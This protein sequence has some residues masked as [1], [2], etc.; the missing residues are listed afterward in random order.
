MVSTQKHIIH[1][2]TVDVETKNERAAFQLKDTIDVF[3]KEDIFP[4]IEA[5]FSSLEEKFQEQTI[6]ISELNIDVN[7]SGNNDFREL[8]EEIK[9]QAFKEFEKIIKSPK[10]ENDK[11]AFLNANQSEER[12]LLYFLEKG[13]P[14]WWNGSN[15]SGF[16]QEK[17]LIEISHS[18]SFLTL[19]RERIQKKNIQNRLVNQFLDKEIQI[20]LKNVFKKE[21][22]KIAILKDK[23][24]EK[25]NELK[26]NIRASI[27]KMYID[28]FLH[29][30]ETIFSEKL[31]A[32]V[33]A[34]GVGNSQGKSNKKLIEIAQFICKELDEKTPKNKLFNAFSFT[35]N[36]QQIYRENTAL[37]EVQNKEELQ[38]ESDMYFGQ[39][40]EQKKEKN[41]TKKNIENNQKT[42]SKKEINPENLI[43]VELRK[44][45]NENK[46]IDS[47]NT[48][49]RVDLTDGFSDFN[50]GSQSRNQEFHNDVSID[51]SMSLEEV[52]QNKIGYSEQEP[53][54][55]NKIKNDVKIISDKEQ[56]EVIK[57]NKN[58]SSE[59]TVFS[60]ETGEY[61]MQNVGLILLHPYLNNFFS[62]CN[63]LTSKKQIS[64]PELAVHLVHYLATKKEQQFECNM[65]FEKF[66]CG[67]PIQKSI[68][69]N[70]SIPEELKQHA[71]E[72]L[73]AV[74]ENWKSL[75][76]ASPE[77]LRNEFLQRS[78]K[79]NF[80]DVNPKIIVER[81]V[82]DILL[83]KI[84]WTLSICKLPWIPK[85]IYTDW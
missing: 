70:I 85:L 78:G 24:V 79:I 69:R 32:L 30:N 66:L 35:Q 26:S 50:L 80:K 59:D 42:I 65:V 82:H 74:V 62:I 55:K 71:E 53:V 41:L 47:E 46:I 77:L 43:D 39:D 23:I 38:E 8:K 44:L 45:S 54:S 19:F 21:S 48:S 60:E 28:Y 17:T 81:K 27:W 52:R 12:A 51:D 2:V 73:K 84:P 7:S 76:N 29:Q 6:Q 72:L 10:I 31:I 64:T 37:F 75:G 36:T 58:D 34:E 57:N 67:V 5:Y 61:Y 22:V 68:Q 20:L 63:L 9:K 13:I 40:N 49:K 25:F 33:L 14:P 4:S 16:L 3:L 56:E 15:E 83:D 11:V 18:A 1:K